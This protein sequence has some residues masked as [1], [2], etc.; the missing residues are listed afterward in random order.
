MGKAWQV[1]VVRSVVPT[2]EQ[3]MVHIEPVVDVLLQG[4]AVVLFTDS[5]RAPVSEDHLELEGVVVNSCDSD[6]CH[7][8][9]RIDQIL[10][11][12]ACSSASNRSLQ[13]RF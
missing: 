8:F 5:E 2:N 11:I 6:L 9:G 4:V 3:A 1:G 10:V 7:K 13:E 12:L